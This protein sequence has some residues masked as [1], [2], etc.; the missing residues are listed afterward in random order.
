MSGLTM[1]VP[2][3]RSDHHFAAVVDAFE[4][5]ITLDPKYQ[6]GK[7]T[8]ARPRASAALR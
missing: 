1:I 8:E 3:A 2:A 4:A 6:D 7:Y 5:M